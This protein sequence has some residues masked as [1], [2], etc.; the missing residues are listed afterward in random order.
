MMLSPGFSARATIRPGNDEV[1]AISAGPCAVYRF[2]NRLS[3]VNR[4]PSDFP[5]PPSAFV[6][7]TTGP[8]DQVRPP[9][10]LISVSP[11]S[12]WITTAGRLPPSIEY[13]IIVPPS[14][15]VLFIFADP[16]FCRD[17]EIILPVSPCI[18]HSAGA[19]CPTSRPTHRRR[20]AYRS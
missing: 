17:T 19:A 5:T 12:S 20:C 16:F 18:P 2:M 4:R 8:R 9:T 14:N 6:S 15:I 7:V 3:P 11:G 13:F 10:S 1:K